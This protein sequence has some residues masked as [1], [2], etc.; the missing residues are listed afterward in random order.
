MCG[1]S[2]PTQNPPG[3]VS[4][5][6][7]APPTTAKCPTRRPA[8]APVSVAT[9]TVA[10]QTPCMCSESGSRQST[11]TSSYEDWLQACPRSAKRSPADSVSGAQG[12][13]P[14]R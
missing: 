3:D 11:G 6:P 13:C 7:W 14:S 12:V 1:S 8:R 9:A 10:A 5:A 4:I 2:R